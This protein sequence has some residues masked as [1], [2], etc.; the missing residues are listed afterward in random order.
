MQLIAY[1]PNDYHS[2]IV[3]IIDDSTISTYYN[4]IVFS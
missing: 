1:V 4:I 3:L 2:V